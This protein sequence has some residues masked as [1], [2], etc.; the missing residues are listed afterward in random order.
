MAQ[1]TVVALVNSRGEVYGSEARWRNEQGQSRRKPFRAERDS[2][3]RLRL[4]AAQQAARQHLADVQVAK[5]S[6]TYVDT[7]L[8]R[9]LYKDW[10]ATLWVPGRKAR[11][12]ST[13][14]RD[15]SVIR[16]HLLP[17]FGHLPLACID[18]LAVRQWVVD[19]TATHAPATVVKAHQLLADSL[20]TAVRAR[21]LQLSPC[22]EIELPSVG[23]HDLRIITPEEIGGLVA[24]VPDQY[25]ALVQVLAYGGLRIG[26]ATA[27]RRHRF[28]ANRCTLT[29]AETLS[30]VS[31]VLT[32]SLLTKTDAGRRTV[33]LPRAVADA[34]EVHLA[35]YPTP[36]DGYIFTAPSGGPFRL[37]SWRR[38]V[39][40]PAVKAAGL[41]PLRPHDLRH[42][43]V[44]LWIKTGANILEVSRRAGHSKA[45]FT[46]DRYGHLYPNADADLAA[47]LDAV[48]VSPPVDAPV[49][50]LR[51]VE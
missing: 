39:W 5:A 19:M 21:H 14:V 33:V 41:N 37:N 24:S 35:T 18:Y 49:V 38:R 8:S 3:G 7:A 43:A 20:A 15:E 48:Y 4:Q 47:R 10:V 11:R 17:R 34:L 28:D 26:E 36:G 13:A 51:A 45:S 29:V 40:I 1:G 44:S 42:T 25:R 46:L 30:E 23:R 16:L 31:G 32:P 27:L 22:H 12:A 2:R 50:Q 6:G 9:M